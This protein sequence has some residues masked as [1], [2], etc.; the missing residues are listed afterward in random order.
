MRQGKRSIYI[1]LKINTEL[2]YLIIQ[3]PLRCSSFH[4]NYLHVEGKRIHSI[5]PNVPVRYHQ[6]E[7]G[8]GKFERMF[9][10][11]ATVDEE[12]IQASYADG[13]LTI[14]MK[15][16]KRPHSVPVEAKM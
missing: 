10:I 4:K 2:V 12:Q 8:H 5:P 3:N 6:I 7:I 13:L 16:E 1:F 11:P 14:R 9:R 15:K